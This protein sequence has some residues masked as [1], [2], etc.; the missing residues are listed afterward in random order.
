MFSEC[1][2][3][4]NLGVIGSTGQ[5]ITNNKSLIENVKQHNKAEKNIWQIRIEVKTCTVS[6]QR[7][8]NA[9]TQSL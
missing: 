2:E 9:A 8:P 3:S 6:F 4:I 5:L 1:F 7:T